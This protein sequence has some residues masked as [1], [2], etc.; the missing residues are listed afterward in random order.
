MINKYR[1]WYAKQKLTTPATD[2]VSILSIYLFLGTESEF[3]D[4]QKWRKHV[5]KDQ[6]EVNQ[7]KQKSK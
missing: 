2:N 4:T 5:A 1:K 3:T 7:A 6:Q